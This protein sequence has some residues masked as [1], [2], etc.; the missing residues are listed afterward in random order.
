MTKQ[1]AESKKIIINIFFYLVAFPICD[2]LV[3]GGP[4]NET[5]LEK[6]SEHIVAFVSVIEEK[7]KEENEERQTKLQSIQ[8][9]DSEVK[10][11]KTSV[12]Y[13]KQRNGNGWEVET[14]YGVSKCKEHFAILITHVIR[15]A[16]RIFTQKRDT[17]CSTYG[18][19]ENRDCW[20]E[21]HYWTENGAKQVAQEWKYF[22]EN[23]QYSAV[24]ND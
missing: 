24:R 11:L 16:V 13:F 2:I 6:R 15:H 8:E 1:L 22:L 7:L 14:I 4:D 3:F 12:E 20:K 17:L 5:T 18:D 23:G 21:N 9:W 10:G 19:D